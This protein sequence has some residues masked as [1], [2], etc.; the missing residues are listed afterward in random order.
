MQA[1]EQIQIKTGLFV[2]FG[3]LLFMFVI[4]LLGSEKRLFQTQYSLVC[5]FK[6]ISGLR[7]GAPVQLAGIHVGSVNQILFD[8]KI[9]A[10]KVKLVLRITKSYQSR[11]REDSEATIVTQ[12]LL[13]DKMVFL[14]L[15]SSDKKILEEGSELRVAPPVGFYQLFE[16]GSTLVDSV[17][18]VSENVN[19]ILLQ[20]K[21]GDSLLHDV[22]YDPKDK[23]IIDDIGA[24]A[25]NLKSAS[26]HVDS[27]TMK[28]NRGEGTLGALV[29]DA[30]LFNDMKTLLGKANRNKLIRAVIRETLSTKEE[31]TLK[32]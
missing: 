9:E 23:E 14:S 21:K 29:N 18:E 2:A 32:P 24:L 15:G 17:T 8:E 30:S 11:I 12:G 28:I 7:V 3:L 27:I 6:D 4:F 19:D 31:G 5:Y 20:I 1:R 26:H 22:L 10:K 16:K 25:K 13:G